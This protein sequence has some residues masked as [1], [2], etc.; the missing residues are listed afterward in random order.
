[1]LSLRI[2]LVILLH[3]NPI[4]IEIKVTALYLCIK[5][6]NYFQTLEFVEIK[7]EKKKLILFRS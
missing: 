5:F 1:M 6:Y 3:I 2:R 4:K 7:P